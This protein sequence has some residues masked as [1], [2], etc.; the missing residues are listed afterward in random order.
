M[1][2]QLVISE[3][4][5]VGVADAGVPNKERVVLRPTQ[6]V[7]LNHF[8]I[9]IGVVDAQGARPRPVFDNVFWFPELLVGPPAWVLVY[10]GRG[11][12]QQSSLPNGDRVYTLFWQRESTLFNSERLVPVLLR[13]GGVSIGSRPNV[14]SGMPIF[15]QRR[16][17]DVW[18]W[19]RNCTSWPTSDYEER[20]Q[21]PG[22]GAFC[23]ECQAKQRLGACR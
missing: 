14:G 2:A 8:A 6:L 10:T 7:S 13:L 3:L 17:G 19:C 23:N 1:S 12:P 22:S 15:R 11:T 16:T 20:G 4:M 9:S 18:H 5:L 21:K